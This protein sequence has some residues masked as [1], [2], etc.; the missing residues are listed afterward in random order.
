M[1]F[2]VRP[3]IHECSGH[4]AQD[5]VLSVTSLR[6]YN[7]PLTVAVM[8]PQ[9]HSYILDD[10]ERGKLYVWCVACVSDMCVWMFAC[11]AWMCGMCACTICVICV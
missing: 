1:G 2:P 3:S 7:Q 4:C 11:G 6:K 8:S 9:G 5:I 10:G